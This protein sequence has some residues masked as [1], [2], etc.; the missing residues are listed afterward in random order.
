MLFQN[1]EG[2]PAHRISRYGDLDKL[3]RWRRRRNRLPGGNL[4]NLLPG[5]DLITWLPWG[6]LITWLPGGNL[7]NRLLGG[8]PI[9]LR[10]G[11]PGQH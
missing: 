7:I 2:C 4:I 9:P 8:N 10:K 1:V 5:G 6:N 3:P 11:S